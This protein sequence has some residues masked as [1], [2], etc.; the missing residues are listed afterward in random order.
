MAESETEASVGI[1]ES[2][3]EVVGTQPTESEPGIAE[4][5]NRDDTKDEMKVGVVLFSLVG[6]G[7][8]LGVLLAD[9]FEDGAF[10]LTLGLGIMLAPL[11]G[12]LIGQRVSA[13]LS[14]LDDTMTFG[15]AGTAAF[16]GTL[17]FGLVLWLFNE[18][19]TDTAADLGDILLPIIGIAIGTA[20]AA[21]ATVWVSRNLIE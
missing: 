18:I 15:T 13:E 10:T 14:D 4:I 9:I 20:I 17:V 1:E 5:F 8:G 7:L 21:V 3:P 11:I 19:V 6:V 16:G 12:V 2:E